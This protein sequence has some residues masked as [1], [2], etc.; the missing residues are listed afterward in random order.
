M[1]WDWLSLASPVFMLAPYLGSMSILLATRD[2]CRAKTKQNEKQNPRETPNQA[3]TAF[4]KYLFGPRK[5]HKRL[6]RKAASTWYHRVVLPR[7]G[8]DF[9]TVTANYT[10]QH[11]CKRLTESVRFSGQYDKNN[12]V[13]TRRVPF[14]Q[15]KKYTRANM[16]S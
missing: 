7:H 4:C 10:S 14:G 5:E 9:A 8:A 11:R 13:H 12:N 3:G 16:D 1:G 2:R 6:A 15:K